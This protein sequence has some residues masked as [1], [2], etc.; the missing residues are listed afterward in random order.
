MC[1]KIGSMITVLHTMDDSDTI[2]EIVDALSQLQ[3]DLELLRK[4]TIDNPN[5]KFSD[6]QSKT[7][8]YYQMKRSAFRNES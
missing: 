7:P 1:N 6:E 2:T 5:F 4:C 8:D 3:Y